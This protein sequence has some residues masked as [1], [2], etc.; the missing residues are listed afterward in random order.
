MHTKCSEAKASAIKAYDSVMT[1]HLNG[2]L[3]CES[4]Q[5]R[6]AQHL[7]LEEGVTLFR[8]EVFGVSASSSEKYLGELTVRLTFNLY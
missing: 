6:Q 4:D 7:A 5:I 3:P 2:L 8:A 1:S